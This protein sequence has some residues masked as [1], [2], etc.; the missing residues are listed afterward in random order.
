MKEVPVLM[1]EEE[2]QKEL[3]DARKCL[4]ERNIKGIYS[5]MFFL[6]GWATAETSPI[7]TPEQLGRLF[8][9]RNE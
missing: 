7:Y 6:A 9:L 2:F 5:R 4:E 1:T 3:E 8:D